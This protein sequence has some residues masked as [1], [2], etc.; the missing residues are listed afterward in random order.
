MRQRIRER[1][2]AWQ[3]QE[4]LAKFPSENPN[5]VL[6]ITR[7]GKLLYTNDAGNSFLTEWG[8]KEGQTVP[9]Y[10]CQAI[11]EAFTSGSQKR[12][13]TE[14]LDR[15]FSFEI[16]PVFE[17][18]YANLYG[19]DITEL[20]Q[21]EKELRQTRS[22]L[23]QRVKKRTFEL[24][25]ANEQLRQKIEELTY[26]EEELRESEILLLEREQSLLEAQRIAH[27]G[28]WEWDIIKNKLWWSDEVHRIFGLEP[29]QFSATY[30]A[31]LAYVHPDD[32]KLVEESVNKAL[33]EEKAYN[34]D[35]RII[36]SDGSEGV[37]NEKA[38]VTYDANHKPLKMTGT[39]HDITEQRKIED[40]I[41]ENQR[42]LRAL[43]AELQLAEEQE[44]RRIAQD[45]HDSIGQILAFSGR[46]LKTLQKSLPDKTA[47][48]LQ[49]IINQLDGAVEQARTLSFNLSPSTLYDLGFEVAI[50]DLADRMSIER[51]IRCHFE[52]CQSPKPL[53]DD[54]KVLLYRSVREL[55]INAAKH[56]N[57]DLVKISILRSSSD[58]YIKVEDDGKGFDTS[59]LNDSSRKTR[60]FGIFSI[61]E[62]LKHIGGR[63]KIESTK[64]KGTRT[65]LIAPLDIEKEDE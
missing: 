63:L 24:H 51:K 38:E 35:H 34:I 21:T 22:E 2:H 53:A 59:I 36:R 40:E 12:V 20:K 10:W 31:F 19:R 16:A 9:D 61:D 60:G 54:V 6:R 56:A 48:S 28:N 32:R 44:R 62:R 23:E 1:D 52:N 64:G 41:R 18:D 5:P 25:E 43:A 13:E 8:C 4:N 55:L 45:L 49:E 65:I 27:L 3:E 58:I 26:S 47:K 7:D 14:H 33:Y 50:E 39:V 15:T 57:A 11:S 37:V 46:E 29:R 17:V 42:A 30:E